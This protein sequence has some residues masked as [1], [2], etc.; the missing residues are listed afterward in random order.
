MENFRK[1]QEETLDTVFASREKTRIFFTKIVPISRFLEKR[2]NNV[3]ICPFHNDSN[4]SAKL[5]VDDDG[6]E[7]LF[8]FTEKKQYTSYDY[9]INILGKD[10]KMFLLSE[11]TEIELNNSVKFIDFKIEKYEKHNYDKILN[12]ASKYLPDVCKFFYSLYPFVSAN[13][14][15][16]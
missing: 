10:P 1:K 9:V 12:N 8:C 16:N 13:L 6:V 11:A 14:E 2:A 7:R 5:F 3:L 4:P 15:G